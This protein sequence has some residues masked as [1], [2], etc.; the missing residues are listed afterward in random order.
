VLIVSVIDMDPNVSV[1]FLVRYCG[2]LSDAISLE[3][4]PLELIIGSDWL[5]ILPGLARDGV[6]SRANAF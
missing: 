4:V 2:V 5:N 1:P 3:A 6:Q